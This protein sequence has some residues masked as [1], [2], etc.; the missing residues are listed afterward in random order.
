MRGRLA[1]TGN[2][3]IVHRSH[4][5]Q[6]YIYC[7]GSRYSYGPRQKGVMILCY[8]ETTTINPKHCGRTHAI[9]EITKPTLNILRASFRLGN[10][11][12]QR[13]RF[14]FLGFALLLP[15]LLQAQNLKVPIV[16]QAAE[17]TNM[18]TSAPTG[19]RT[20]APVTFGLGIPDS[21][22]IDCPGAQD[23]PQNEQAPTKL[24]LQNESGARLNSQFRCM[25]KWPD[26]YAKWVLVDAQLPSFGDRSPGFDKSIIVTQVT[27]GGGNYP[28]AGMALQCKGAGTPVAACPDANHIV[29][30]TGTATFLIK[31]ANYNLFDEVVIGS[32]HI[33]SR[34]T[35]GPTDGIFLQGPPDSAIPPTNP[36]PTIDSASCWSGKSGDSGP[37]PTN[38]TGPSI[39]NTA[40]VSANDPSST[41]VIEENGPLRSVL[42]C[43]GDLDNSNRHVYMHWRTRMHFWANHSDVKVTVALRNADVPLA[44]CCN[45]AKMAP[46]HQWEIAYKEYSQLGLRLTDNLGSSS[47]RNFEIANDSNVP[48]R[49]TIN[50]SNGAD[51]AYLFQAYSQDGEWP[52]WANAGDCKK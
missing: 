48:T 19:V 17:W 15:T 36:K 8:C 28:S 47:S 5:I 33:V 14:L 34:A 37:L 3:P 11:Q 16:V 35:H 10:Y 42:M 13:K 40:Y 29:V 21:A 18:S 46:E 45:P 51:N 30:A 31:E 52:H 12:A 20:N 39:C 25:A 23:K 43:Q 49:G 7:P 26:G 9:S 22:Q 50:P 6:W 1:W 38:Y 4:S 32:A 44:D 24:K 41:C 27:S 2:D